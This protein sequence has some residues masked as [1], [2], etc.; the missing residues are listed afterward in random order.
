M[1]QTVHGLFHAGLASTTAAS[2]CSGLRKYLTFCAHFNLN[3][4]P[5][6]EQNLCRFVAFLYASSFSS[7]SVNLYLSALRYSQIA[8]GGQDPRFPQL[9]QL[10]YVLRGLRRQQPTS[11]R[12]QRLPITPA[13]MQILFHRW[14]RAPVTFE[15][16]ML[17]AACALGFFGFLRSGE[18]TVTAYN[19]CPLRPSDIA[20]DS[21]TLP[22]IIA[23]T[24]RVSKTDQFGEGTT[25]FIGKTG[26]A[27]CPVAAILALSS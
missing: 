20:V 8:L 13:I 18:F 19:S 6:S 10:Q 27:L 5:L 15:K 12:P 17:W 26:M 9:P 16:V 7:S 21:H 1:D 25:I 3:P 22:S 2:Y 11:S 24:V 4:F 23:V 14:S